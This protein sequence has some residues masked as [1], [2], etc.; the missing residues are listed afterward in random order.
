MPRYDYACANCGY[1]FEATQRMTEDPLRTCPKCGKDAL[2][3]IVPMTSFT[4]KGSGWYADGY[5]A[6]PSTPKDGSN[7]DGKKGGGAKGEAKAA[8]KGDDAK[9]ESKGEA[10]T[11]AKP[12]ETPKSTA[13]SDTSSKGS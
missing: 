7:G 4:L 5:G 11:E 3:R 12:V 8:S 13:P 10:K 1:Q 2:D 9:G 6:H